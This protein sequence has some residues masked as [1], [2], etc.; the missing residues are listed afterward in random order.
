M[1]AQDG[2]SALPAEPKVR[3]D[4]ALQEV[5]EEGILYDREGARVHVLNRT[6]LFT[7]RLCDGSRSLD[8][9]AAD[10]Q[11]TFSGVEPSRVR[12]DVDRILAEFSER[13]LLDHS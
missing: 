1:L 9:I 5:G 2:Q 12:N 7:W 13:G 4:L 3:S 10:I 8:A 6:A 11:A